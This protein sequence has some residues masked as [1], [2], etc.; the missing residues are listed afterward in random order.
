MTDAVGRPQATQ[1]LRDHDA[2]FRSVFNAAPIGVTRVDNHA[3][4]VWCNSAWQRML[5]YT[6][7][8]LRQ[9]TIGEIT[10]P[11]DLERSLKG[12]AGVTEGG[13]ENMALEKRYVRKDGSTMWGSL[14]AMAVRNE[15]G[16]LQYTIAI[17]GKPPI[18][19][20][21]PACQ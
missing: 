13:S 5:G 1:T 6:Q 10:H 15:E 18:E 19:A 12:F 21:A 2:L 9:M 4:F 7:E 3:R 17:A 20:G 16:K 11:D 8:E 14:S